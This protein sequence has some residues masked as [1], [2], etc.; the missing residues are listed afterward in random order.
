MNAHL[1]LSKFIYNLVTEGY[2]TEKKCKSEESKQRQKAKDEGKTMELMGYC[3]G[4]YCFL[5]TSFLFF[6][7]FFVS[8][9][10]FLD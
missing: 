9:R 3:F 10:E 4:F 7:I 6:S 2:K 5:M 8:L 1:A